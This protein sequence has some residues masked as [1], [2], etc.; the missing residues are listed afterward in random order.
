MNPDK[1]TDVKDLGEV[2]EFYV[3]GVRHHEI[4]KCL[5]EMEVGQHLMMEPEPLNKYDANAVRLEYAAV[6]HGFNVMIGY[7]PGKISA[8]VT[9]MLMSG[10]AY[11]EITELNKDEKPW[12]QVKVVISST[13]PIDLEE[14]ELNTAKFLRGE[15]K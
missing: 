5:D 13:V 14:A 15:L 6:K 9:I 8:D 7:V 2:Y 12:K 10:A 4:Y 3:A 1:L 11:C